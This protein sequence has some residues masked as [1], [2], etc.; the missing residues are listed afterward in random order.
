MIGLP[1]GKA[2]T[3]GFLIGGVIALLFGILVFIP[4]VLSYMYYSDENKALNEEAE[5][6]GLGEIPGVSLDDEVT[7]FLVAT[8][9]G[10]L[11]T[12]A[13]GA[14]ILTAMTINWGMRGSESSARKSLYDEMSLLTTRCRLSSS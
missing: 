14:L 10:G 2:D 4:S 5:R 3:M 8:V 11:Y 7:F 13:G 1:K 6:M 12:A 9:V